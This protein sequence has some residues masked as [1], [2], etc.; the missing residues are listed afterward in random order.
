MPILEQTNPH[1]GAI[2]G[3]VVTGLLLELYW[4]VLFFCFLFGSVC[5]GV[6]GQL[7]GR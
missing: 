6:R 1:P 5:I 3:I 4:A 2:F 7:V